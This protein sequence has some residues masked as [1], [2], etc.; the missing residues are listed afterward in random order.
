[1][2]KITTVILVIIL[3]VVAVYA[4]NYIGELITGHTVFCKPD[5][6]EGFYGFP[7]LAIPESKCK[8]HCHQN[9]GITSFK[10]DMTPIPN[11]CYCDVNDCGEQIVIRP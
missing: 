10:I 2:R 11:L 7:H 4:V 8:L 5:Y 1:M 6:I 9:Y 3:L